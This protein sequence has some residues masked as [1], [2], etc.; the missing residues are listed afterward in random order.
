MKRQV[1]PIIIVDKNMYRIINLLIITN[2]NI[3][4]MIEQQ[5]K[6]LTELIMVDKS[7]KSD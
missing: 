5:N 7:G 2:F 6:F 4:F 3:I 1:T